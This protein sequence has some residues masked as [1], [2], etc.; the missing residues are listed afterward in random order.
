M[1][2]IL[3]FAVA[4]MFT[5][6]FASCAPAG[7]IYSVQ[8]TFNNIAGSAK[9]AVVNINV[10][11]EQRFQIIEPEFF[12]FGIPER[13]PTYKYQVRGMGSGVIIDP[14][15][16]VVTNAHVVRGADEIKVTRFLPSGKGVSYK[17][18]VVGVD[19][20]YDVALVKID[21]KGKLPFLRFADFKSVRVGDWAIAIGSPFGLEQTITVGVIS[22]VRQSINIEGRKYRNLVQTDAAINQGNSGGPLLNIDGR[23]IGINTAIFSPSGAFAGVGFAIPA[24][25]V[26]KT[27]S[28]LKSP[29]TQKRR[30][31]VTITPV[32]PVVAMQW[33]LPDT[34]GVLVQSVISGSPADKAKIK[35]GDVIVSADG[36]KIYT[37]QD[38]VDAINSKSASRGIIL[39]ILRNGK[40]LKISVKPEE[41]KE[42]KKL[43]I[44]RKFKKPAI[45]KSFGWS[46][47]TVAENSKGV[48]VMRVSGNSP[49][50][51]YLQEGDIIQGVNKNEIN[52]LA[53]FKSATDDADISEGVVFDIIR[54]GIP[55][56]ISVQVN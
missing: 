9:P 37:P 52:T 8:K 22:A 46:G 35:R 10:V 16:Y 32:D 21:A 25:E 2:K 45:S 56:Y 29:V 12:F 51:G 23:I 34:D 5:A 41:V 44:L 20:Y 14:K 43:N 27:V 53:D 7:D 3:S 48:I 33:Q 15:G 1:R 47:L 26:Q 55:V 49:L 31:G 54:N 40:K 11:S 4:G 36:E 38:L 17:G 28:R 39:E 6:A 13:L 30:I 24:D 50:Y 42:N 19:N 18:T